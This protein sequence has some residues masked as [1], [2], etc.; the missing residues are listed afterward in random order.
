MRPTLYYGSG[1]YRSQSYV[2]PAALAAGLADDLG[3]R[4][5]LVA[6]RPTR[7]VGKA[8][9]INNDALPKIEI[10]SETHRITVDGNEIIPAP[11]SVLPLAQL[12]HLF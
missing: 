9:M 3:L 11:A 1:S 10:D 8:Q 6:V 12:Y 2:A 4:R 5:E 7:A